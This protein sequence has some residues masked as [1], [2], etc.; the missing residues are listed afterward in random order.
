MDETTTEVSHVEA[1]VESTATEATGAETPQEV[2]GDTPE[3]SEAG[4]S[5]QPEVEVQ[6]EPKPTRAQKRIEELTK[7]AKEAEEKAQYWEALNAKPQEYALEPDEDGNVTP[8]QVANL[9]VAKMEAK[10]LERQRKGA[11]QAMQQDML[12]T[13]EA[14][15]EL[16]DDQELAD[17]VVAQALNKGITLKASADRIMKRFAST[18]KE[19]QARTLA[20]AA[21]KNA[22]LTPSAGRV[23]SGEAAPVDWKNMSD[24]ERRANWGKIVSTRNS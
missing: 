3:L 24:D 12:S 1:P 13:Y 16:N 7:R 10:E 2:P 8:E 11:E 9:T 20:T 5:D 6:P 21:S 15:P 23:G 18:Q 4:T 17:L 14:Y 19:T 22:V